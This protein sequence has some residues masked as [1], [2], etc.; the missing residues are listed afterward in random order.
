[1]KAYILFQLKITV[2]LSKVHEQ[3]VH[4]QQE[5]ICRREH[6]LLDSDFPSRYRVYNRMC[7]S[8]FHMSEHWSSSA[9][10]QTQVRVSVRAGGLQKH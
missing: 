4:E 7:Q 2:W 5:Q 1:M 10:A 9:S 8:E 3:V 6:A